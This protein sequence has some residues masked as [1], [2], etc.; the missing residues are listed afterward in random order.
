MSDSAVAETLTPAEAAETLRCSADHVR[1][2]IATKRL[3]AVNIAIGKR[4][5]KWRIPRQS[6]ADLIAS[7]GN[8]PSSRR[9]KPTPPKTTRQWV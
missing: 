7:S 1:N 3:H 4:R 6:I 5:A 8:G 2:L 9:K